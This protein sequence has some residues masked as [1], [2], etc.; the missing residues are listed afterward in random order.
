MLTEKE[1]VE[2]GGMICPVC[3]SGYIS[4]IVPLDYDVGIAWQEIKCN[5]CG[6]RWTDKYNLVGY[7]DLE[8]D[9]GE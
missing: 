6:A 3:E 1:Y 5:S 2:N 8:K 9:F 7:S 4:S